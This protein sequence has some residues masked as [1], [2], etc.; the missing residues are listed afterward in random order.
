VKGRPLEAGDT[1]ATPAIQTG[2]LAR[3]TKHVIAEVLSGNLRT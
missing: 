3:A 1:C 2:S